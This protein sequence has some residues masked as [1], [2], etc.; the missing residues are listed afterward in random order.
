MAT[1]VEFRTLGPVTLTVAEGREMTGLLAQPRRLA[2]LAY[3]AAATPRGFH[4][5]DVVLTV[6]WPELD[7]EHA[8]AAL[9]QALHVIRGA[10]GAVVV[11]RG[12]DEIGLDFECLRCDTDAFDHAVSNDQWEQALELYRGVL[13]D[14]FFISSAPEFERWLDQERARL[15]ALA[16]AAIRALMERATAAGDFLLAA[17]WGRRGRQL[18]PLDEE[19]V[20]RLISLLDRL[21]DRAGAVQAFE[22]FA[23]HLARELDVEPAP[24]TKALIEQVRARDRKFAGSV[25]AFEDFAN[26]SPA[27]P[28]EDGQASPT[29]LSPSQTARR[30]ATL[31][32]G[33]AV[34][35]VAATM[36]T[37][38]VVRS[39]RAA[40]N[41][42]PKRVVVATFANR[43]GDSSLS[44]LGAL[45][46]D[47]INHELVRTGLVEVADPGFDPGGPGPGRRAAT[48]ARVL[49][50]AT[51]S[52]T[53]VSGSYYRQGDSVEFE[54]RIIDERS[55]RL[56]RSVTQ[57]IGPARD[58]RAAVA[59]LSQRVTAALA[60]IMN[61]K[62]SEFA[63]LA[64][65]PPTY[66]AYRE[67]AVG[68]D[69][70]YDGLD[71]RKALPYFYRAARLDSTYTLPL[72]WATWALRALGD[73]VKTDSIGRV[74]SARR[75]QLALVDQAYVGRE[76]A[77]CRGDNAEV[78]RLSRELAAALPG[79]EAAAVALA[80]D[81]L[82][83]GHPHEAIDILERLHPDRG[84]LRDFR[85]YYLFL[86]MAYHVLGEHERELAT[87]RESRR[88]FPTDLG[89]LRQELFALAALGRLEDVYRDL[90]DISALPPATL[91]TPL[92]VFRTT[93]FEL[94]A[95]GYPEESP[96]VL[97]RALAWLGARPSAEQAG[98]A[99]QFE[100]LE[101]LSAAERWDEA[102][103]LAERLAA[104]HP[105]SVSYV[106]E[107]G[108]LAAQRGDRQESARVDSELARWTRPPRSIEA[109][110]ARACIAAR[111]GKPAD[112][113]ARLAE[114]SGPWTY[115]VGAWWYLSVHRDPCF[116][117][118]RDSAPFRELL[119][120][121]G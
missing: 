34:I 109:A 30:R 103:A 112:A 73:C 18:A 113:I 1:A 75:G 11:S 40:A 38:F 49:A 63:G 77:A 54:A 22:D 2:L 7:Q 79:S 76:L 83:I 9:R 25:Q 92:Q 85:P 96:V 50:L 23:N 117:S 31:T 43:S 10:L 47:W 68:V 24:E 12:D 44:S 8:R 36:S 67:F 39:A 97:Q 111:L 66:E 46:S 14:G 41:L 72:V 29:I 15:H 99:L 120:L 27:T 20:R 59:T 121:K 3:L 95:H 78:Y 110:Y 93:A 61:P 28:L 118:L 91:V 100:R 4:R 89:A 86:T 32:I 37:A 55:G 64:S 108:T 84:A 45:A 56:L 70:W 102:R 69:W 26:H 119:R 16:V 71:A 48:D 13:L 19:L 58:P 94:R 35:L 107:L 53:T 104:E 57:V 51:G 81:A 62:L 101:I 6:F 114:A 90:D 106:G 42:N 21:G 105:D 88:R 52:G 33:I 116:D 87:A 17:K 98:E 115:H 60:T 74:L 80:R 65:Q 82:A 5:R